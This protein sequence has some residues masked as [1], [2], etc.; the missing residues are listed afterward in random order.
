MLRV[1]ANKLAKLQKLF[2]MLTFLGVFVTFI[3]LPPMG[4]L[5]PGSIVLISDCTPN[6]QI[7]PVSPLTGY[8]GIYLEGESVDLTLK[9]LKKPDCNYS[10]IS[11]LQDG[12]K[13]YKFYETTSFKLDTSIQSRMD[14]KLISIYGNSSDGPYNRT[15]V[16]SVVSKD[17]LNEINNAYIIPATS[18]VITSLA[19]ILPQFYLHRSKSAKKKKKRRKKDSQ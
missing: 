18:T 17:K 9:L 11:I 1:L 4:P 7:T 15:T 13:Q 16:I 2:L 6:I 14:E 19:A 5:P 8:E 10:N 3:S 12:S